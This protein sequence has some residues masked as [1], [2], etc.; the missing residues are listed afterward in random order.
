[1]TCVIEPGFN[2]DLISFDVTYVLNGDMSGR[3]VLANPEGFYYATCGDLCVPYFAGVEHEYLYTSGERMED[4]DNICYKTEDPAGNPIDGPDRFPNPCQINWLRGIIT[5]F[6]ESLPI[7]GVDTV[8]VDVTTFYD[9]LNYKP[10]NSQSFYGDRLSTVI[11]ILLQYYTGVPDYLISATNYY[12]YQIIGPVKGNSVLSELRLV[13]QAGFASV[14]TQVGGELEIGT[15]H[16]HTSL[17]YYTLGADRIISCQRATYQPNR[18]SIV[19]A[20]GGNLPRYDCGKVPFTDSKAALGDTP[21]GGGYSSFPGN[22][23]QCQKSGMAQQDGDIKL[24]NLAADTNDLKNA[25]IDM[26][27]GDPETRTKIG[28]GHMEF[29]TKHEDWIPTRKSVLS[30]ARDETK[31]KLLVTGNRR[32][33]EK[34]AVFTDYQK[35][36]SSADDQRGDAERQ[37]DKS[38]IVGAKAK[39]A[40]APV[41]ID[42][43]GKRFGKDTKSSAGKNDSYTGNQPSLGA[44]EIVATDNSISACGNTVEQISNPYVFHKETLFKLAVRRFQELKMEENTWQLEIDYMPCL[45]INDCIEFT[46]PDHLLSQSII[47]NNPSL[48]RVIKGVVNGISVSYDRKGPKMNIT[49]SSLDCLGQT[50]YTSGNLIDILCGGFNSGGVNPWTSASLGL[51]G[52]AGADDRIWLYSDGVPVTTYIEQG[53]MTDG[54]QYTVSFYYRYISGFST[55]TFG[56]PDNPSP[57][58]PLSGDGFFTNTWIQN[59]ANGTKFEW[60]VAGGFTRACYE[61]YNLE[62]ITQIV[63]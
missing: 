38:K 35:S 21:Q 49:V 6:N 51:D 37:E 40:N 20:R 33:D 19:R 16:D 50:T 24:N 47:Q 28:D 14:Y 15:W 63:A 39:N 34:Q 48:A 61:I 52:N 43:F 57:G 9:Y 56:W 7:R 27:N 31:D 13:A 8:T 25:N 42:S 60:G 54:Q 23:K 26:E 11:P 22:Q 45:K 30:G 44:V 36:V 5:G 18:T 4:A 59:N 2:A 17:P 55:F 32:G 3:A 29:K 1:M 12:D 53:A 10:I 62:L 58:Q 46:V 41:P